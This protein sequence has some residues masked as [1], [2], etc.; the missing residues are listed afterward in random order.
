[1]PPLPPSLKLSVV[2]ALLVS[3]IL[4]AASPA[5]AGEC[6]NG[7]IYKT[8]IPSCQQDA[9]RVLIL[10]T[11]ILH[12]HY[13]GG[14]LS[15]ISEL[16]EPSVIPFVG[17]HDYESENFHASD[18]N[19]VSE[20][21]LKLTIEPDPSCTSCEDPWQFGDSPTIVVDATSTTLNTLRRHG[22]SFDQIVAAAFYA[23]ILTY[24]GDEDATLTLRLR[25][26]KARE[27]DG[28][29]TYNWE[30]TTQIVDSSTRDEQKPELVENGSASDSAVNWRKVV[31]WQGKTQTLANGPLNGWV[32][33]RHLEGWSCVAAPD[34]IQHK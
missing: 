21:G 9:V 17:Y 32:L 23:A 29:M 1:M 16:S 6:A 7:I 12:A 4:H 28:R 14:R 15:D 19:P 8:W 34:A 3:G 25:T 22:A 26:P 13:S 30:G 11:P 2:I 18:Q 33:S 27:N 5:L 31:H 24:A 10:P 20:L